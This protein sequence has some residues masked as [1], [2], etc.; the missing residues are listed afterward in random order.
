LAK[1]PG[2]TQV[3]RRQATPLDPAPYAHNAA[4]N[5]CGEMLIALTPLEKRYKD[6]FAEIADCDSQTQT[7]SKTAGAPKKKQ[8]EMD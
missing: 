4:Q 7:A 2:Q 5:E 3:S 1:K 8:P 6:G